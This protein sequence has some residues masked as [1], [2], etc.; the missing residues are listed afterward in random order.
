MI[1]IGLVVGGVV[2][3]VA[4]VCLW[5]LFVC[6]VLGCCCVVVVLWWLVFSVVLVVLVFSL[7]FICITRFVLVGVRLL[8]L[9]YL[10][11]VLFGCF[12]F[13]LVALCLI[14]FWICLFWV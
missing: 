5:V 7:Y 6:W 4:V 2:W 11:V 10:V 3:V 14:L 13:G 12:L 9:I 8:G 1:W